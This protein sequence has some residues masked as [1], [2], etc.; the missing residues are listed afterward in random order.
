MPIEMPDPK[1]PNGERAQRVEYWDGL[2]DV[3]PNRFQKLQGGTVVATNRYVEMTI[4]NATLTLDYFDADGASVFEES[5]VPGG[6]DSWD[7]TLVRTV[8]NDPHILGH[9]I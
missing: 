2:T 1:Y 6:G 7:G 8:V 4:Q 5:F 9:I 3:Y